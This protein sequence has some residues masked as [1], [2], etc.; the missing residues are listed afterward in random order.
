MLDREEILQE[1]EMM[2]YALLTF[3]VGGRGAVLVRLRGLE[4]TVSV[5]DGSTIHH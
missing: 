2:L 5:G 1:S 3:V 4:W